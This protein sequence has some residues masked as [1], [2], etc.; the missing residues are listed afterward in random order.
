MS[1]VST[2][3]EYS[4]SDGTDGALDEAEGPRM[5]MLAANKPRKRRPLRASRKKHD[6]VPQAP[7][8]NIVPRNLSADAVSYGLNF[9]D[10]Q[11]HWNILIVTTGRFLERQLNL[12]LANRLLILT[13]G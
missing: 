8:S 7:W 9:V 2:A 13:G 6:N 4:P 10:L 12:Q 1:V 3:Y 5:S 11:Q